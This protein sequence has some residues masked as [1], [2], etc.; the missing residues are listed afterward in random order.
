MELELKDG[1][2]LEGRIERAS[3]KGISLTDVVFSDGGKSQS[4]NVRASRLQD[5][6][7]LDMPLG[8]MNQKAAKPAVKTNGSKP[9]NADIQWQH[10]D[11]T[12]I[13]EQDD[14]DFQGNLGMFNK[15]D[16]FAELRKNDTIASE[17]RLVSHNKRNGNY[18]AP[19]EKLEID[20]MVIPDAK[21]DS[22]NKISEEEGIAARKNDTNIG[23]PSVDKEDS[24]YLPITE[25]L[26]ITHLLHSAT[27][28]TKE[29]NSTNEGDVLAKLEQMIK[30]SSSVSNPSLSA[31][32]K[33]SAIKMKNSEYYVPTATPVQLLEIERVAADEFGINSTIML[34][35][36]ALNA[37]F[38]LKKKL[39][40]RSRLRSTNKNA[41]PLVVILTS[42]SD[43]A[44]S[45][46]LALGRHL[47]QS[48][49]IRVITLFTTPSAAELLEASVKQQFEKYKSCGGKVVNSISALEATLEQL[50][51]PVEIVIDAMQGFDI[52]LADLYENLSLPQNPAMA[53]ASPQEKRIRGMVEWCNRQHSHTRIWSLDIPSGHDSAAGM[54]SF[55]TCVHATGIIAA[56]WPLTALHQITAQDEHLEDLVMIDIGV[57]SGSYAR[58]ASLRRFQSGTD[59]LVTEG[60]LE[61]Q[62]A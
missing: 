14:F 32:M 20:E 55:E 21:N 35:N 52:N 5:L 33:T 41:E 9:N 53:S 22:W 59:L 56:G 28:D 47:C 23:L 17:E 2:V 27:T 29:G 54:P 43:R 24:N 61:L 30:R 8:K 3:E 40:G 12:K 44:G 4:F 16:V 42:D 48:G 46:A 34:E 37:G 19:Q 25:S 36:F 45:R 58:R 6:K 18:N 60:A 62:F 39:G 38:F 31:G 57:P 51:S 7:V 10:D 49:H 26:N 11:V 1:K 50:N 15:K 13:K